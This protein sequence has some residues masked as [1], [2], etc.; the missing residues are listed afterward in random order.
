MIFG[1][2]V[3]KVFVNLRKLIGYGKTVSGQQYLVD[4][5]FNQYDDHR[6]DFFG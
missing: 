6:I 2:A 5:D 4:D 1:A 3:R